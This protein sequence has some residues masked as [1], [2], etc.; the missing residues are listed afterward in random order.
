MNNEH[1]RPSLIARTI[2]GSAVLI[3]L[4]WI[5]MSLALSFGL[6][7]LEEVGREHGMSLIPAA[8]PSAQAMARMGRDFGESDSNSLAMIV[9]EGEQPLGTA[10]HRYYAGL[11][12]A[13]RDDPEHV[14]HVQDLWGDRLTSASVQSADRKATYVQLNLA[15]D[16]GI[17]L[18]DES[19][20][21][22]RDIVHRMPPPPGVHVYVTGQAP[23]MSDMQHSGNASVV[24]ITIVTVSVIFVMLLFVYRSVV[25]V[26]VLLIMV[27]LE[28]AAARGGIAFLGHNGMLQLSTFAVNLLTSLAIAT[29][30]D[31]GIFFL[32]RYQEA[33]RAGQDPETAYY[34]MY[35]SVAPVVLASGV[36]IAGALFCLRFTRL[37]YFVSLGIPCSLGMLIAVLVAVTLV[38]AGIAVAA[39]FG[40]LDPK[41]RARTGRWRGVGTAIVRWPVPMLTVASALALVG[42]LALA[43]YQTSYDDRQYLPAN[44]PANIGFAAAEEHFSQAR[45]MPDILLLESDHDMR[46]QTDFLVLNKVAKAVFKIRGISRVQGVTRP[47]GAPLGKTSIPFLLSIQQA[48]QAQAMQFQKERIGDMRQQA[49]NLEKIIAAMRNQYNVTRKLSD[50]THHMILDSAELR[51]VT[52]SLRD[53]FANFEDF[54]RPI[55]AY[56]QWEPH[57]YDIP[58]CF[59]IRSAF[60]LLDGVDE[61]SEQMD[62]MLAEM[63]PFDVVMPKVVAQF[64]KLI[65]LMESM[66]KATMTTYSTM[67]GMFAGIDDM[68]QDASAMGM[69]FD[70]AKNDESFYLPPEVLDSPDF[71]KA[72]ALFL[73]PDGKAARFIISHSG[74]P[75]TPEGIARVN[76]IT[77]AATEALK[78][79]PLANA[80]VFLAGASPTAKDWQDG[81]RNDLLIAGLAALSLIFIVMLIITRALVAALAIVGTVLVSLGASFGVS[82]LVWQH[83]FDIRLHWMVLAMSVIILLAV[84]SDYNLLLVSRMKEEL[85][86][87]IN[88][89]TIRAMAGTGRVV[90]S[91]GLVFAFTMMSMVVSD[92]RIIG[93]VGTTIGLGLLFDTFIVRAL[94]TPSIARIFGRWFWWPQRVRPRPASFMLEP[95]GTRASV[96]ELLGDLAGP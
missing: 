53:S 81:S 65:E 52:D 17:T 9:I 87:G 73:S 33:R 70:A 12:R 89:G 55:R 31:Y 41:R 24:T 47:D 35:R 56:F 69:A 86:A 54:I 18:G 68:M 1:P 96:R 34:T 82:V 77:N 92:L 91:A 3:I 14:Q 57:C 83:I 26:I 75:A 39:R 71:Q 72:M 28:L 59:S 49:D 11:I 20:A 7:S 23:L 84:G 80:G 63:S 76:Q 60:E 36:T 94:M 61:A 21:A 37:P 22:V 19:V 90:T 6:P 44:I 78:G 45:L 5:A 8:A 13:L 4:V 10:A 2:R 43:G 42:L 15:G 85:H 27:G 93:Q 64:P 38:P 25:T 40:L 88:T 58:I 66:R 51:D 46:N 62:L 67:S 74:D 16:Q 50:T 32:G 30:T 29:G 48:G 79:T 95:Y